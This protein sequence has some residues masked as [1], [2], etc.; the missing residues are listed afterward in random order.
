MF[1]LY[2]LLVLKVFFFFFF[3]SGI[4]LDNHCDIV[5][6]ER[7]GPGTSR[8][9]SISISRFGFNQ[10]E[11]QRDHPGITV[12]YVCGREGAWK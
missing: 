1:F 10:A 6:Q 12:T 4:G 7:G 3:N 9:L 8:T 2:K 11:E 5:C